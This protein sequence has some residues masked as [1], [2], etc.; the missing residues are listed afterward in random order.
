MY[1]LTLN[2]GRRVRVTFLQFSETY[3]GLIEGDPGLVANRYLQEAI[4]T[5]QNTGPRDGP[6]KVMR[7]H[8]KKGQPLPGIKGFALLESFESASGT[9]DSLSWLR[10]LWFQEAGR[11]HP[12]IPPAVI[13][14]IDWATDAQ[15]FEI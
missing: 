7:P 1:R 10:L 11:S 14:A 3:A 9:D 8:Q 6:L 12:R 13:E 4:A 5:A 2:S 15:D